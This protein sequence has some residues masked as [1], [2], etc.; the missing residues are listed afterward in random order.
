MR[1]K[2]LK[3]FTFL[4]YNNSTTANILSETKSLAIAKESRSYRLR[5][6]IVAKCHRKFNVT[7]SIL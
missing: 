1:K 3:K 5:P 7:F 2:C 4:D 6:I